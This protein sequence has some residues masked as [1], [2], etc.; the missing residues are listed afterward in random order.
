MDANLFKRMRFEFRG[1]FIAAIEGRLVELLSL[2]LMVGWL[3][4]LIGNG[5]EMLSRPIY[6]GF[7]G[8]PDPV[9]IVFFLFGLLSHLVS[10]FWRGELC[11]MLRYMALGWATGL[12]VFIA[13][14]FSVFAPPN[15]ASVTYAMVGLVCFLKGVEIVWNK[16][17]QHS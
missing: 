6:A 4:R 10:L 16:Y 3:R 9:W 14:N 11:F 15:M 5:E 1:A 13:S 2:S 12:W 8:L 7:D 17:S